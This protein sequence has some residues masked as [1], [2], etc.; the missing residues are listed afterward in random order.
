[1]TRYQAHFPRFYRH[2]IPLFGLLPR[3]VITLGQ[4]TAG[5]RNTASVGF[6]R[7]SDSRP[8][9]SHLCSRRDKKLGNALSQN[10]L[11]FP[12]DSLSRKEYTLSER[13]PR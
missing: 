9:R 1:M 11:Q 8:S 6:V 5:C 7:P 4:A 2:T 3:A 12:V 10:S 13:A